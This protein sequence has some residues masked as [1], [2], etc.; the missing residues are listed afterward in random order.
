M[1]TPY[2]GQ[3]STLK[4]E[5]EKETIS[6]VID[7]R[8]AE[9]LAAAKEKAREGSDLADDEEDFEEPEPFAPVQAVSRTL[10]SQA[11]IPLRPRRPCTDIKTSRHLG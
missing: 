2:L 6:V 7:E 1:I 5:L 11:S 9:D 3:L 8:D 10:K 4:R